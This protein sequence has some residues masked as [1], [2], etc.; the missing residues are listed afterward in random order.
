MAPPQLADVDLRFL[1]DVRAE[2]GSAQQAYDIAVAD[3]V[4]ADAAASDDAKFSEFKLG[5][6]LH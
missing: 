1:T 6:H 2:V 4:T 3:Q 5:V